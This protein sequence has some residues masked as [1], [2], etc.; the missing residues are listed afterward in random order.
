VLLV[1]AVESGLLLLAKPL[2]EVLPERLR[3]RGL[4]CSGRLRGFA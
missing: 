2:L 3:L 1:C 4:L